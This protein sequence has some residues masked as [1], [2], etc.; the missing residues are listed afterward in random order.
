MGILSNKNIVVNLYKDP[1]EVWSLLRS[2][3]FRGQAFSTFLARRPHGKRYITI[4]VKFNR[5]SKSWITF[6]ENKNTKHAGK[7]VYFK[8][9]CNMLD[10][11]KRVLNID[12]LDEINYSK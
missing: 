2:A 10:Y 4:Y 5:S 12:I 3:G 9:F 8:N 7:K 6:H 1:A 11:W